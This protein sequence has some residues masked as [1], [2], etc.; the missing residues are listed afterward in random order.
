LLIVLSIVNS[1][2]LKTV[3]FAT[4]GF[5]WPPWADNFIYGCKPVELRWNIKSRKIGQYLKGPVVG[6]ESLFSVLL[7]CI[8]LR[9]VG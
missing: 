6:I 9:R 5:A 4:T 7:S 3:A 8:F 1:H 2:G